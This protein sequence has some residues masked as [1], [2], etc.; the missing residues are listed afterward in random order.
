MKDILITRRTDLERTCDVA[1]RL[2]L[3]QLPLFRA[4]ADGLIALL[5]VEDATAT[6][7]AKLIERELKRC[8]PTCFLIG[9]DPGVGHPDPAPAEWS[10]ARR[11]KYWC[12]SAIVH[13]AG[14]EADHYRAAVLT[15]IACQRLALIET[16]SARASEWAGFLGCPRT[17]LI[18]PPGGV[19][20]V[21]GQRET[22]Q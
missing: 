1:G 15:T 20:P 13:G 12:N 7:P 21:A 11:L 6:W 2:G 5:C 19:H 8:R 18:T 16:T 17:L 22:V 14:G 9:G 10:C 4:A 3:A